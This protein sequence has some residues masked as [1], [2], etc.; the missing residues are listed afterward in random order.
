MKRYMNYKAVKKEAE[1][2]DRIG[3]SW[4][5]FQFIL[6]ISARYVRKCSVV[7]PAAHLGNVSLIVTVFVPFCVT[8]NDR[9]YV[10][11]KF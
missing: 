5:L 8:R 2:M 7:S 10:H 1:N 9:V 3:T 11:I 6:D 4:R